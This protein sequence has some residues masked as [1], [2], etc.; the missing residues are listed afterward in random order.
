MDFISGLVSLTNRE[1]FENESP[2]LFQKLYLQITNAHNSPKFENY[3]IIQLQS[4]K[5][6]AYI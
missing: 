5:L 2:F 1:Y 3:S 6:T 4:L